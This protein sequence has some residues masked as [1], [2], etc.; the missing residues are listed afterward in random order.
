[1]SVRL[2][3]DAIVSKI[4]GW[5]KDD[6]LR[7]LSPEDS[8]R[9]FQMIANQ[10]NDKPL[11]LP[12]IAISRNNEIEITNNSKR[13]LTYDGLTLKANEDVSL[14]ID[15]I[16]MTLNYQLDI[17]T[18]Y[19]SEADEYMRNFVF[20]IINHPKLKIQLPYNNVDYIHYAYMRILSTIEDNSDIPQKLFGDQFTR[21]TIRF[22]VDD[23]YLFSLPYTDNVQIVGYE[24]QIV[25][26]QD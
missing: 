10:N 3:D 8:T 4:K 21:W 1:M 15:A 25:E 16:P 14:H 9:L 18:R 11:T 7:V 26:K 19:M 2:Y 20:S 23:A 22:T 6:K 12:L 24:M 13:M 5:I 17:Y